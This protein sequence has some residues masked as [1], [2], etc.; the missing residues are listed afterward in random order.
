MAGISAQLT[1]SS[2]TLTAGERP[3]L[4]LTTGRPA[5]ARRPSDAASSA[6]SEGV[7]HVRL[8][9]QSDAKQPS[10]AR[11]GSQAALEGSFR[12]SLQPGVAH[13]IVLDAVTKVGEYMVHST[14]T[15]LGGKRRG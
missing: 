1:A 7:L 15:L 5:G 8:I 12:L 6:P 11:R 2:P 3:R 13:G 14:L 9:L 4:T 10:A